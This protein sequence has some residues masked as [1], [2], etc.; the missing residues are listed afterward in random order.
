MA[1]DEP[2]T[3]ISSALAPV[4]ALSAC[5]ILASNAQTQYSGLIDRLRALNA[6]RMGF[7]SHPPASDGQAL[8]LRS[9][10]HQIPVFFRRARELRNAIFLLVVG[11]MFIL[12]TS[13]MIVTAATFQATFLAVASKWCFFAGLLSVFLAVVAMLKEVF[14]TFRVVRYELGIFDK[15]TSKEME[16]RFEEY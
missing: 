8:R 9:L 7:G 1:L 10:E 11:M 16:R 14:L 12:L 4:V 15:A 5:A 3:F 6:E 13:F 2:V